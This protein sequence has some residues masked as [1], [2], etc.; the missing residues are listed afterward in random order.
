LSK[1]IVL[2]PVFWM[3]DSK[4]QLKKMPADVQKQM[5]GE[6]YLAQRGENP[7]H[8]KRFKGVG[9]GV[10][11]IKDDF[12]SNTFRVV[13]AVQI[14]TRIFVL[15]AFQKKSKKGIAT[16]K[17]DI[18]LIARRYHEAVEMEKEFQS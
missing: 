4:K 6:L 17:E 13:Y 11:E 14:G 7:P 15:H 12:E 5:G 8:G 18:D 1:D 2:R 3:G 9:S 10:F 16:P